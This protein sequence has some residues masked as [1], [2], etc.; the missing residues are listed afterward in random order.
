MCRAHVGFPALGPPPTEPQPLA[1]SCPLSL[2]WTLAGM[3]IPPGESRRLPARGEGL[4]PDGGRRGGQR[5]LGSWQENR[6][7]PRAS[8]C[9]QPSAVLGLLQAMRNIFLSTFRPNPSPSSDAQHFWS[10]CTVTPRGQLLR[11]ATIAP[12]HHAGTEVMGTRGC[13]PWDAAQRRTLPCCSLLWT[14]LI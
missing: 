11:A 12:G 14:H 4:S 6:Q 10:D 13:L 5:G 7:E 1:T 2:E 9:A 3:S 8:P